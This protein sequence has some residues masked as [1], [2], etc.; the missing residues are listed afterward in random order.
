MMRK[1]WIWEGVAAER[2]SFGRRAALA[3]EMLVNYNGISKDHCLVHRR[4]APTPGGI[5]R[6]SSRAATA[7]MFSS[8]ATDDW[9]RFTGS[10]ELFACADGV[11]PPRGT[12]TESASQQRP[13][14]Q[15]RSAAI[16]DAPATHEY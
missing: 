14:A 11:G 8:S 13:A 5:S 16:P 6:A 10:N 7:L 1:R 15:K 2:P 3:A 12:T 4:R 9:V